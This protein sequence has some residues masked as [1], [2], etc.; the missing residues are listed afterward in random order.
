MKNNGRGGV[1]LVEIILYLFIGI[2]FSAMIYQLLHFVIVSSHRIV[3]RINRDV[4]L[5]M[6]VDFLRYDFWWHSVSTATVSPD[7]KQLIFKEKVDGQTKTVRYLI[8]KEQNRYVL[9]RI[10][11]NGTNVIYVSSKEMYFYTPHEKIWGINIEGYEFEMV[12]EIPEEVKKQL[13][14]GNR[15]PYFLLPDF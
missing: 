5:F 15:L 3:E 14:I 2:V 10:A 4:D 6:A 9:K 8:E 13:G 12:N 1:V 11:N 7:G